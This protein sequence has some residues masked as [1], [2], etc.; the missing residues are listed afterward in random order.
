MIFS[1]FRSLFGILGRVGARLPPSSPSSPGLLSIASRATV[2]IRHE[3]REVAAI[4]F[5]ASGRRDLV[6]FVRAER[7]REQL[8]HSLWPRV[9]AELSSSDV[10]AKS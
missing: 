9:L 3:A 8:A 6:W 10:I 4:S 1:F 7:M 2:R 5:G